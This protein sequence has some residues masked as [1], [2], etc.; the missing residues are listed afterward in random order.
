PAVRGHSGQIRKAAEMLLAAKRPVLYSG[1]GVIL[2]GGSAPL[3]ELA[4][5]LNLPVTNTLMGLGGY[6]GTDRQFIGML[7]MHGSYTAN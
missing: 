5:M 6:P 7:G 4:Q 3:T 1:G 2:G